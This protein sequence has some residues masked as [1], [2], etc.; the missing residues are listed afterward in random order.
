MVAVVKAELYK[1]YAK[2]TANKWLH[3]ANKLFIVMVCVEG[4]LRQR[5]ERVCL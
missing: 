5:K 3:L 2:L 1:G 4:L